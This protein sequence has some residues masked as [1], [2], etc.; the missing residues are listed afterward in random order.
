M[1]FPALR[2]GE[3]D[4]DLPRPCLMVAAPPD[5]KDTGKF[6]GREGFRGQE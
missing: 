2:S 4:S 5:T 3:R 6:G 1:P